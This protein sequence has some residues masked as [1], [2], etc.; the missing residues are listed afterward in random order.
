MIVSGGRNIRPY[1]IEE[2]LNEHPSVSECIA[3]GLPDE[4]WGQKLCVTIV[5]DNQSLSEVN[6][7]EYL[8]GKL[9]S[10]KI[11]KEWNFQINPLPRN[12]M[13]KLIRHQT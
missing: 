4:E 11:P 7:K 1:E 5:S 8:R 6:L 13:G 10:W 3:Y 9:E 2:F 12:H